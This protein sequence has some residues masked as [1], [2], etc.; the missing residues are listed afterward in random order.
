[1][2]R[3]QRGIRCVSLHPLVKIKIKMFRI[4]APCLQ[5]VGDTIRNQSV[6]PNWS[7][8]VEN[9]KGLYEEV[10]QC[11]KGRT[12]VLFS[13]N[14][15]LEGMWPT[16]SRNW[17]A[18]ILNTGE[19]LSVLLMVS[20]TAS[21]MPRSLSAFRVCPRLG[22]N[23]PMTSMR[24]CLPFDSLKL[25]ADG[26]NSWRDIGIEGAGGSGDQKSSSSSNLLIFR[27]SIMLLSVM[28]LELRWFI[29]MWGMSQVVVSTMRFA[30][31]PLVG[32]SIFS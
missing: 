28:I 3:H 18:R 30:W 6:I 17:S 21:E 2:S 29:I 7:D 23:C 8:F 15:L 16:I 25:R 4:I 5:L 13:A 32:F 22:L 14:S 20:A 26:K 31:T 1:M 27:H 9:L 19:W 10:N 12:W 24:L 11:P